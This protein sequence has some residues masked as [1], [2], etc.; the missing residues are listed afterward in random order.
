VYW[1][2]DSGRGECRLPASWQIEYLDQGRWKAVA[3]ATAYPVARDKWCNVTFA[4]VTTTAL[5]LAVQLPPDY[6]A[7]VHEWKV[8]H[9]EDLD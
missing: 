8:S 5:R 7:G 4:P 9:P 1:F 6:A 3:A 2:D